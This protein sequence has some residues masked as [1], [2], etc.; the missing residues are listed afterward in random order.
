M[1]IKI[2]NSKERQKVTEKLRER[3]G[4]SSI[5]YMIV[6]SGKERLRITSTNLS[7]DE[8]RMLS[9]NANIESIGLYFAT[10]I[11][12]EIRL[13]IDATHLLKSQINK[14]ILEISEKEKDDWLKGRDLQ[15]SNEE[16][17]FVIIK[18]KDDLLGT[19]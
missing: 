3:F 10:L 9:Q 19:G 15:K 6:Q 13:S 1:E 8:I 18:Y 5:P 16:R 4:I 7:A 11:N 17:G 2:L 12:D 14:N